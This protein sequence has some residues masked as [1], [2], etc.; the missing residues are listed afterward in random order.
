VGKAA[1]RRHAP[2][3]AQ[4]EE[5]AVEPARVRLVAGRARDLE[6]I[7]PD[8]RHDPPTYRCGRGDPARDRTATHTAALLS[9]YV[10]MSDTERT[11]P[12]GAPCM[13]DAAPGITGAAT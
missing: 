7:E 12:A 9:N 2:E 11:G 4:P 5:P 1:A 3:A 8:D 10:D 13:G 6:V